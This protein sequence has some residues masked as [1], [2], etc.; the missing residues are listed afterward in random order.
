MSIFINAC[1]LLSALLSLSQFGRWR[2]SLVAIAFYA[3]SLIFGPRCL[4]EFTLAGFLYS[5]NSSFYYQ[6]GEC[7][8]ICCVISKTNINSNRNF[9]KSL[10][11]CITFNL[12]LNFRPFYGYHEGERDFLKI[13][14]YNPFLVT[15]L[16]SP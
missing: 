13:S 15:R 12:F 8:L 7:L 10:L 14:L 16:V 1:C 6:N 3:L 9:K 5:N 4:S 2:L 11:L